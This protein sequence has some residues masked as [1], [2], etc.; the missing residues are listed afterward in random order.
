MDTNG[1]RDGSTSQLTDGGIFNGQRIHDMT[2]MHPTTF[3]ALVEC[4]R[5][6]IKLPVSEQPYVINVETKVLMF[7]YITVHG[8][9]YRHAAE[10]FKHSLH[11]IKH[12]FYQVIQACCMLH[13][14]IVRMP[15]AGYSDE[16]L[17]D[18]P[19]HWPWLKDCIGVVDCFHLPVSIP[20]RQQSTWRNSKDMVTQNV[21]AAC[22]FEGN[23]VYVYAGME[24][25]AYDSA[26]FGQAA[27]KG[28]LF[29]PP[30]CFFLA[31]SGFSPRFESILTP[32]SGTRYNLKRFEEAQSRPQTP[33]E[34]F[35][36]RHASLGVVAERTFGSFRRRFRI[37]ERP[38][39]G[40]PI[41]TQIN[42]VFALTAIH[43]F[44][45]QAG[46]KEVG[47]IEGEVVPNDD[48]NDDEDEDD[49]DDDDESVVNNGM[50]LERRDRIAGEMWAAYRRYLSDNGV[51]LQ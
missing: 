12:V 42:L 4:L 46:E 15:N 47:P 5:R 20:P 11:T 36:L 41:Q 2:R 49:D 3:T 14:D 28:Q 43:N 13:I 29:I 38:R 27:R 34:L 39:D 45:N 40:F 30:G 48:D 50:H 31:D 51:Q 24:G 16:V 44:V 6:Y 18:S 19:E 17:S 10:I 23:F 32:F 8:V 7:L 35:N 33:Q 22:D 9:S 1:S 26:V 21:L 37:L 25:S